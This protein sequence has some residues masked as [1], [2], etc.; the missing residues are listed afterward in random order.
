MVIEVHRDRDPK[1]AGLLSALPG[2]SGG[3]PGRQAHRSRSE[4]PRQTQDASPG[5]KNIQPSGSKHH[6]LPSEHNPLGFQ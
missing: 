3:S 4:R 5:V 2:N 6:P 1:E